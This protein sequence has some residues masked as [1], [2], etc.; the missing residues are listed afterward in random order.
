MG[1]GEGV[2]VGVGVSVGVGV[3]VGVGMGV[4][5]LSEK[6]LKTLALPPLSEILIANKTKSARKTVTRTL[7]RTVIYIDAK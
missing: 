1:V 2:K 3:E 4:G 5:E 7:V 6:K